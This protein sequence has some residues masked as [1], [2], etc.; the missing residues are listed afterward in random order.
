M[1]LERLSRRPIKMRLAYFSPLNPQPSGISD[2]SEELLPYLSEL[3][4]VDLFVDGFEPSNQSLRRSFA[5]FDYRKNPSTLESLREYDAIVYHMG[6]DH[7]YHSGMLEVIRAHPGVVVFHDFALQDFFFGLSQAR[8]DVALYLNEV[9]ACHGRSAT[10]DAAET[11]E[12]G[13]M[14][15]LLAR[16]TDFPLNCELAR[17][18]EGIIVHSE[19]SRARFAAIAPAVPVEHI[20]MP[21]KIPASN[22]A[23]T[24]ATSKTAPEYVVQIANFGLIT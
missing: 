22:P 20:N 13:G 10:I 3:C 8:G 15:A 16:P 7:R 6:N 14:P 1:A 21:I 11:M 18:A 17:L 9:L 2:Y 12:R 23:K 5:C 19:W 4:E 24:R